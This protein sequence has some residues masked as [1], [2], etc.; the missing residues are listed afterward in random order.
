VPKEG[1][2]WFTLARVHIRIFSALGA[3]MKENYSEEIG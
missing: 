1:I 2:K 3:F